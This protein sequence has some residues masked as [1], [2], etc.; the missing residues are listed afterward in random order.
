[1]KKLTFILVIVTC[2]TGFGQ[3]INLSEHLN[4]NN[5]KVVN[6]QISEYEIDGVELD[7]KEGDGLA[8]LK[9]VNFKSGTIYFEIKGENA[10]GRSFVGLAFNVQNDSTYEAIYFRPFNFYA[11][12]PSR[13]SH[14]V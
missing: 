12:E 14:M 1:M 6:R 4:S 3:E 13:R 7:A 8:I 9:D 11:E 5:I 2:H 10:P